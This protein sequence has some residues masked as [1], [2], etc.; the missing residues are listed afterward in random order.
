MRAGDSEAALTFFRDIATTGAVEGLGLDAE[1]DQW[2]RSLGT[3]YVEDIRRGRMRRDYG[4]V[5]LSFFRTAQA[6]KCL[7][8]SVQVHRLAYPHEDVVP[9]TLSRVPFPDRVLFADLNR[10]IQDSGAE[11]EEIV[12]VAKSWYRRYYIPESSALVH[13]VSD[14]SLSAETVWSISLAKDAETRRVPLR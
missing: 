3:A 10:V 2:S 5:E 4:L 11:V 6:W 12:D 13:V 14:D 7:E 8:I 1:P 9:I